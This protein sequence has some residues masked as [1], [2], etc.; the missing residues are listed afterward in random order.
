[1]TWCR[2]ILCKI[3]KFRGKHRISLGILT[4]SLDIMKQCS[5]GTGRGLENLKLEDPIIVE[6]EKEKEKNK[7]TEEIKDKKDVKKEPEKKLLDKKAPEKQKTVV[8]ISKQSEISKFDL[9]PELT[10]TVRKEK[11]KEIV[12]NMENS[13]GIKGVLWLRVKVELI[14]T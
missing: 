3:Y 7:L 11:I 2:I 6:F 14:K 12:E 9:M 13:T 4:K 10:D 1:M 5:S 8:K